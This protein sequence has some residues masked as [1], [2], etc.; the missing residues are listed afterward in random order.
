MIEISENH[1]VPH[2]GTIV[3]TFYDSQSLM[4]FFHCIVFSTALLG[5]TNVME[6]FPF[7]WV[8]NVIQNYGFL[9]GIVQTT[10]IFVFSD[11]FV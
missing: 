4:T 1:V 3:V 2:H 8:L 7:F 10:M 6:I 9:H 5:G 11:A